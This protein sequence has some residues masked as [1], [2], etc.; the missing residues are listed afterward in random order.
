MHKKVESTKIVLKIKSC[1]LKAK[2]LEMLTRHIAVHRT[3]VQP[4]LAT[5]A[6]IYDLTTGKDG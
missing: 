5:S 2:L 6:Q 3:E 4:I 1:V